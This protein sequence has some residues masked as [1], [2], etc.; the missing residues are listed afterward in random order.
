MRSFVLLS[1]LQLASATLV[2]HPNAPSC[3]DLSLYDTLEHNLPDHPYGGYH[4]SLWESR[5][6]IT[7]DGGGEH[8]VVN[9]GTILTL[10]DDDLPHVD[11]RP[12]DLLDPSPSSSSSSSFFSYLS[13]YF[14]LSFQAS[15]SPPATKTNSTHALMIDAGSG[16]S[17]LHVYEFARREFSTIPPPISDVTTDSSWTSRL[18]PGLSSFKDTPEEVR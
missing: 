3:N 15:A 13:A 1:L 6:D 9:K 17:R 12:E 11:E 8:L 2:C 16:G 14:P 4:R 7:H 18:K 5:A 10:S